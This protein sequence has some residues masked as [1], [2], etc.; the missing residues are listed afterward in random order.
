[1][2]RHPLRQELPRAQFI[3]ERIFSTLDRF[4]H[5]E[6]L[7]GIALIIA[8]VAAMIWA[9]SPA[10]GS[11]QAFW[12]AP[13]SI[14]FGDYILSKPLHFWINDAL[15]TIFFLV[16]GIEIRREIHQG[17]LAEIRM[18][19]LPLAAALGG[20]VVPALIY[21]ALNETPAQRQGWAI[22]TATDI[23]FAVG[24]LALLG[25]GISAGIR[26]FLLT[27]AIIDDIAAVFIIA[28]FYS[29]G[30]DYS[31]LLIAGAGIL[32]VLGFQRIGIG[33]A[34]GY[35]LPG[36]ILWFGLLKTGAH[37]TLAGVV[38]GLMTPVLPGTG[39]SQP[40]DVAA[41]SVDALCR[42][43]TRPQ[44]TPIRKLRWAQRELLPPVIR[45]QTALHPWVAFL[46]M[47]LFALANA[48]VTL[49]GGS[50]AQVGTQD[51]LLGIILGLVLGKPIGIIGAS[52]LAVRLGWCRLPADLD[53]AGISLAALLGG[54]GFTM[55]IFVATLAFD[56][57]SLLA[58]AKL[59]ILL[60]SLTAAL[61]GLSLGYLMARRRATEGHRLQQG[62]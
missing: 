21:S 7:S 46:V 35:V 59:G 33:S 9:N 2:S 53:W 52:W 40:L 22:P 5:I 56:D 45:V 8:A 42:R 20:V 30:L 29:G 4:L 60:A 57:N 23:A 48:G 41:R 15:M 61:I 37:P 50:L 16:I 44:L 55:S 62:R 54:I 12:H 25:R 11:Y 47:P 28:A 10:A 49:G 19:T 31:G 24:V 14:G 1:M 27:F 38:L 26:I 18:A 58:A 3:T 39:R 34:W 17:A 13:L 43:P 32:T 6:A 36:A 51:V